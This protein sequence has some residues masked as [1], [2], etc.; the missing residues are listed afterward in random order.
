MMRIAVAAPSE[1]PARRANTMQVMKMCQ[2]IAS[3]DCEVRL[4]IPSGQ[5]RA[6]QAPPADWATLQA[7]YGLQPHPTFTLEWLPAHPNL[8]RYDFSL[9]SVLKARRWKADLFYTRLPQAA[10]LASR[11]GV[12]TIYEIHDLPQGK[13]NPALLRLFYSGPGARRLVTI[14][15]ALADDLEEHFG[16]PSALPFTIVAPDGVDLERYDNLPSP[17]LARKAIAQ[18]PDARP[19]TP[20]ILQPER[21]T[22]GYTG[23]LYPGRGSDMILELAERLPAITF[24]I[25]GGEPRDVENLRQ[26]VRQRKLENLL[27][28]GFIPNAKLPLYQAACDALLMPY[29]S[30]VAASSGGDIAQYLSPMKLFEYLACER[31]ILS[32]DLPVLREI[33]NP[34]NAIL[35]PTGNLES[36]TDALRALADQPGSGA[37][38][39]RQA[40][41]DAS[42][43]SWKGR[44]RRILEGLDKTGSGKG[45]PGA[46]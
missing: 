14:T 9:N 26:L 19:E 30:Q 2:A 31:A 41:Q 1:I 36:W 5:R 21:F 11:L 24:L 46:A 27:I 29:Q 25:A 18:L 34:Q 32:S 28:T 15:R 17:V 4:S 6:A 3:L 38:L 43:Y 12:P 16:V 8:K 42:H 13:S 22:A 10:A 35:L 23:H 37:M 20:A 45:E 33:L 7:H 44:A 39:A 40:R